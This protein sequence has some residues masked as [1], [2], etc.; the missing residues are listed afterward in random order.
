MLCIFPLAIA[1][2]AH[3]IAPL[4]H[5]I[6]TV[7]VKVNSCTSSP[8]QIGL[9]AH[10][11]PQMHTIFQKCCANWFAVQPMRCVCTHTNHFEQASPGGLG[12]AG[13]AWLGW[14][15]WIDRIAW[16][17]RPI[18]E[19]QTARKVIPVKFQS[20]RCAEFDSWLRLHDR[21]CFHGSTPQLAH[22]A[23]TCRLGFSRPYNRFFRNYPLAFPNP[24]SRNNR[25]DFPTSTQRNSR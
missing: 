21:H 11:M 19:C 9:R 20:N 2:R 6:V 4:A 8:H 7:H 12:L 18:A 1:W 16:I 25:Q 15:D 13:V 17:G 23:V 10:Q 22:L 14:I 5:Q 3:K 24:H